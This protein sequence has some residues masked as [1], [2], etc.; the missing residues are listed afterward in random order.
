MGAKIYKSKVVLDNHRVMA[1]ILANAAEIFEQHKLGDHYTWSYDKYNVFG[2]TSPTQ[3]FYDLFLELNEIAYE[4][5]GA[6]NLWMQ[7]WMNNDPDHDPLQRH[8]HAWNWHGYI[9]IRPHK[10]R[11]VFDDFILKNEIGNVYIGPGM[12]YHKVVV[13]EP[14]PK[15]E[16]RLTI[17]FDLTEDPMR[18]SENVGLIPFPRYVK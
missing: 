4:Y 15:D 16:P 8:R 1:S 2:L 5:T 10:T 6:K 14:Y 3:V 18:I 13:D 11:T 12:L 17:G 9:S 7:S